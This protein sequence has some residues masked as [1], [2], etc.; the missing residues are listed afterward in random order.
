MGPTTWI[1]YIPI[2]RKAQCTT[3]I[4]AIGA[5]LPAGDKEHYPRQSYSMFSN[6]AEYDLHKPAVGRCIFRI[7]MLIIVN[8][9][10]LH[11]RQKW[12]SEMAIFFF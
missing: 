3:L 12:F 7:I 4:L 10:S 9:L 6:C 11:A 8:L 2:R 1:V 5:S